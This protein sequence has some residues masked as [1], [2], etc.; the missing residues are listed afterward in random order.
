[1]NGE[2]GA[3]LVAV[4]LTM[5]LLLAVGAALAL[6]TSS[7]TIVAA[8]FAWLHE[9]RYAA[10]G[11]L[12]RALADIAAVDD[13]NL[14]VAGALTSTFVDGPPFGVRTLA[15]RAVDL[16]VVVNVANCG[17]PT[18]CSAAEIAG[19]ATGQ[20]PWGANNPVWHLFAYGPFGEMLPD[21]AGGS[22]CYVVVLVGDD[23]AEIDGVPSIDGATPCDAAQR[24]PACNP[25]SGAIAVRAE[26][27]GPAG[28]HQI[29]EAVVA[30]PAVRGQPVRTR[31]EWTRDVR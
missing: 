11:A 17:K 31:A 2:R 19:N 8:N 20:R 23:P 7:E 4:I 27:F 10:A 29:A 13:W 24:P 1:M 14:L 9:A 12:D 22:P 3:A 26:A 18:S 5:T 15:G 28:V 30:R 6:T 25:G 21:G 16:A